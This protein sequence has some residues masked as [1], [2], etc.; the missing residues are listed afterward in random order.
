MR[1]YKILVVLPFYGGSLPVG[2]FA[3]RGLE[4]LGHIVEVFDSP[5]FYSAFKALKQIK[6]GVSNLEQLEQGFLHLVSQAIYAKVEEFAP[7]FVLALAQAPLTRQILAKFRQNGIPT[8]MW[9][10]EDFQVFTYWRAFAP[11]YDFFAVIQ[12]E[13]FFSSLK[14]IGQNNVC[15]LPLACCPEV[16]KPLSLNP[17]DKK[18]YG[19]DLS[20]MGAGYPN[21]RKVFKELVDYDFKIWGTE[22]EGDAIL[23]PFVQ[24]G[25]RRVSPEEIVKI[26][27]AS[28]INLNLHSSVDWIEISK[29][30]FVNPRTFEIAGCRAFQLVDERSLLSELF[31]P[32]EEI[33]VFSSVTELKKQIDYFLK[34][35]EKRQEFAHNAYIR[36]LAEHTYTHRMETLLDFITSKIN[37]CSVGEDKLEIS[38]LPEEVRSELELF[39][40]N[41]GLTL[42]SELEEI[43]LRIKEKQG[44]LSELEAALLF[45]DEWKKQYLG[46]KI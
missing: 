20:F 38:G 33:V 42:N 6:I 12:K 13:P 27:N 9:F 41:L 4:Q 24:E 17:V 23:T 14:K 19:S 25:G 31:L 28:K 29:G 46:N 21:R 8:V 36:V 16:H 2:R 39:L 3:A 32:D 15:Y 34:H 22:W 43:V 5:L 45:L 35:P 10:V 11:C 1:K 30:D 26:F 44:E 7:S 18:R 40:A 37:L